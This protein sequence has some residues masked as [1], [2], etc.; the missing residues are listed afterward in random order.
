MRHAVLLPELLGFRMVIHVKVLD[1][2]NMGVITHK[3][4]KRKMRPFLG[5]KSNECISRVPFHVKPAQLC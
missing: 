3:H 5:K 1:Q 2:V 4:R